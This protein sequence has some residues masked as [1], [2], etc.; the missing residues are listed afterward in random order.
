[1]RAIGIAVAFAVIT[2]V[3]LHVAMGRPLG[4]GDAAWRF[5]VLV[6][7]VGGWMTA[8]PW[9]LV[10]R[11]SFLRRLWRSLGGAKTR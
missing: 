10:W 8:S 2:N 7:G 11:R 1:M 3:A 4:W 9:A 5:A 6:L